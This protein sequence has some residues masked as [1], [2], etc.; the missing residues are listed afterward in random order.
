MKLSKKTQ[1]IL[2]TVSLLLFS[3]IAL[4]QVTV[5]VNAANSATLSESDVKRIFLGK[6]KTYPGAGTVIAVNLTEG[7]ATKSYFDDTLL[8]KSQSQMKAF[9]AKSVFSGKGS[10]PQELASDADIVK[11]VAENPA[12]IGYVSTAD[13]PSTVKV[14]GTF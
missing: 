11:L 9:W 8:G 2:A 5:I 12:V 1:S 14:V 4:S 7:S 13:V 6:M 3:Q 10:P